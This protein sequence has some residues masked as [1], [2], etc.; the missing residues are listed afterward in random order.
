M[1]KEMDGWT[2]SIIGAFFLSVMILLGLGLYY[3]S[4]EPP[5]TPVEP[6][7][8]CDQKCTNL[9]EVLVQDSNNPLVRIDR[10][11][12]KITTIDPCFTVLSVCNYS[13]FKM[14]LFDTG[15]IYMI[16][17][18]QHQVRRAENFSWIASFD[19]EI[20]GAQSN[21]LVRLVSDF[22]DPVWIWEDVEWCDRNVLFL[23]TTMT[24]TH[25]YVWDGNNGWLYST[26]HIEAYAGCVLRVYGATISDFVEVSNNKCTVHPGDFVHTAAFGMLDSFNN[27]YPGQMGKMGVLDYEVYYF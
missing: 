14:F 6:D 25:L 19:G 23:S 3:L 4:R 13:T 21:K 5:T 17:E 12:H 11:A 20:Y 15:E 24:G 22:F 16:D 1:V 10:Q 27:F 7:Q 18:L 9:A 26:N 8:K 2:F